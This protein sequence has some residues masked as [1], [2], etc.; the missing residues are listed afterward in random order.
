MSYIDKFL[1]EVE[2]DRERD[3]LLQKITVLE[4]RVAVLSAELTRVSA[5]LARMYE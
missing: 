3:R 2:R 5:E 4:E 1:D